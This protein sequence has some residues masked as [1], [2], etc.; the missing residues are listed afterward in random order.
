MDPTVEVGAIDSPKFIDADACAAR[1]DF[2]PPHWR[3]QVDAGRAPQ[4]TRF[5]QLVR[6]SIKVLDEWDAA[7]CPPVRNV[8]G[9]RR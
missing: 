6:W 2:S 5:G 9:G 7:G 3:R 8:K 1:Y 4:P